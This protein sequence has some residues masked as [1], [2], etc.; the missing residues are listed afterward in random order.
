MVSTDEIMCK[1]VLSNSGIEPF[2]YSISPY[3]GCAHACVYCYA[4]FMLRF[5]AAHQSRQWGEFADAKVNA[6][7]ALLREIKRKPRGVTWLSAV[8]D[9]YQ[10]IEKK[11]E[12]TRRCLEILLGYRFP[13]WI[14]TKSS[15]VLR[16]LDLITRFPEKDVGFTILSL[17]D[18]LR[19][20]I[21][22]GASPIDERIAALT[23][24]SSRGVRTFAFV[25]PI[26]PVLSDSEEALT[27]LLRELV[28]SGASQVLFDRLNLRW[29]VWPSMRTFLEKNYPTL[30]PRYQN[31]MFGNSTYFKDLSR[32]IRK[33]CRETGVTKYEVCY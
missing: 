14:Q 31:I 7:G 22:P 6:A 24:L 13:I 16:D 9:P 23:E 32:S 1:S 4:R 29:G 17:D 5:R 11:Y 18:D 25:G 28:K 8:T 26:L 2:D 21:E 33:A 19:K 27:K 15:M 12:L 3:I 20:Q 10:P 30:L